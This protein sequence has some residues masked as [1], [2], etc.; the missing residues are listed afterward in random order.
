MK[1]K[2]NSYGQDREYTLREMGTIPHFGAVRHN[3]ARRG[4]GAPEVGRL[5]WILSRRGRGAPEAVVVGFSRCRVTDGRRIGAVR[6]RKAAQ[7]R[8]AEVDDVQCPD[9]FSP[10]PRCPRLR[11]EPKG[12]AG[13]VLEPLKSTAAPF[14]SFNRTALFPNKVNKTHPLPY[15]RDTVTHTHTK[16]EPHSGE[17]TRCPQL[18]SQYQKRSTGASGKLISGYQEVVECPSIGQKRPP[19]GSRR[20]HKQVKLGSQ[21]G[22]ARC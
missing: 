7:S 21:S 12:R 10:L 1:E 17:D 18:Q 6:Q 11:P 20:G 9:G 19:N 3:E 22:P 15:N 16:N 13:C 8:S 2:L 5:R 4:V 14:P